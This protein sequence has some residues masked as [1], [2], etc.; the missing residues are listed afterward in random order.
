MQTNEES[1]SVRL[2]PFVKSTKSRRLRLQPYRWE[3]SAK[4]T[5]CHLIEPVVKNHFLSKL[6]EKQCNTGKQKYRSLCQDDEPVHPGSS[7]STSPTSL[8]QDTGC[9]LS[10]K[11]RREQHN[12]KV[13]AVNHCKS[14]SRDHTETQNKNKMRPPV[15]VK[16]DLLRDLPEWSENL[17]RRRSV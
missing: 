1:N 14:P 15:P 10:V 4:I 8:Q 7:A 11:S 3:N 6:T 17:G 13:P 16:A 12:V 5:D 2:Q 9:R